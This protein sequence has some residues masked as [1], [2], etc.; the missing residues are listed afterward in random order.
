MFECSL[1]T[2]DKC[3]DIRDDGF[4]FPERSGS[5]NEGRQGAGAYQARRAFNDDVGTVRRNVEIG[6]VGILDAG[7][8]IHGQVCQLMNPVSHQL[9]GGSLYDVH[10]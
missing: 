3:A 7:V 6:R 8:Y 9:R 1:G 4:N 2:P 5:R 10:T